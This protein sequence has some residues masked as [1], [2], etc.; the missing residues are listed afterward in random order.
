MSSKLILDLRR[1]NNIHL[2]EYDLARENMA[3]NRRCITCTENE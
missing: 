1:C 2:Y 3:Y